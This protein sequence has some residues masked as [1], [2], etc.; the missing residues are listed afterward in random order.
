MTISIV[1]V[2]AASLCWRLLT[3]AFDAMLFNTAR[4]ETA[5]L[6][7]CWNDTYASFYDANYDTYFADGTVCYEQ[8]RDHAGG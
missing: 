7:R 2:L 1:I 4:R 6:N 5:G 3:L 8:F